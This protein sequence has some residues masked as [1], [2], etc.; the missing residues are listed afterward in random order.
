MPSHSMSVRV[1]VCTHDLG[2]GHT[3]PH[4]ARLN[5]DPIKTHSLQLQM[6]VF[7]GTCMAIPTP[8]SSHRVEKYVSFEGKLD[9]GMYSTLDFLM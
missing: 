1:C 3:T 9:G 8:W 6:E 5:V 4:G 2:V 7:K